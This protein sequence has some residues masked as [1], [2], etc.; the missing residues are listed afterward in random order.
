[1]FVCLLVNTL[2][3]FSSVKFQA[4]SD[5]SVSHSGSAQSTCVLC[6]CRAAVFTDIF[7]IIILILLAGGEE[8]VL[9][10]TPTQP[11]LK[12]QE[13]PKTLSWSSLGDFNCHSEEGQQEEDFMVTS[14]VSQ[15]VVET[16]VPCYWVDRLCEMRLLQAGQTSCS[17]L[18]SSIY[19]DR[20]VPAY[21]FLPIID[22]AAKGATD[23]Y[24]GFWVISVA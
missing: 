23:G 15:T 4:A 14:L 5:S 13:R 12:E 11:L 20:G 19:I 3:H 8:L 17:E 10:Y 24:L 9:E 7:L 22:S 2:P 18:I 1:M 21:P 16:A 6:Q